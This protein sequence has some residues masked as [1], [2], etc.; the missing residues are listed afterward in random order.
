MTRSRDLLGLAGWLLIAFLAATIGATA[1]ISARDFY[2][3]M[4]RPSWAPPGSVFGPVWT[5]LYA[6][7]GVAAW[8]VWRAQ[9]LSGA[10]AALLLFVVQLAVN[11]LW[12]WLF[13]G[14]RQGA[15]AFVD[16]LVLWVL[17]AATIALFGRVSR[18]AAALLVPYLAWVTFASFLN[19]SIWR[20]NPGLLG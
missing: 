10:G 4:A 6:M 11:A 18:V 2:A 14:W 5:A 3:E 20:L 13:F 9:G 8:L 1:S 17:I 15:L 12:S 7:M 19:F 16:I